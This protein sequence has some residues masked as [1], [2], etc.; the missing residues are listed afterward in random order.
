MLGQ[1]V[2]GR[3][4]FD[5]RRALDFLVAPETTRF[6]YV[7]LYLDVA[8]TAP[9]IAFNA[10][11]WRKHSLKTLEVVTLAFFAVTWLL[12]R[13]CDRLRGEKS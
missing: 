12:V 4:A 2:A 13:F 8:G 6:Q 3:R 7:D 9:A 5:F 1:P 10:Y 11:R